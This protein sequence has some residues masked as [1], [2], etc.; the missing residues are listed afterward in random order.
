MEQIVRIVDPS[1]GVPEDPALVIV[2]TL[3][4]IDRITDPL[5]PG[6]SGLI[7]AVETIAGA[8]PVRV[9]PEFVRILAPPVDRMGIAVVAAGPGVRSATA[10]GAIPP[11][12]L[13]GEPAK[14]L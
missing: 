3:Q 7:P 8:V 12:G 9:T 1:G 11:L 10:A 2:V 5:T 14:N 6:T 4:V 13:P